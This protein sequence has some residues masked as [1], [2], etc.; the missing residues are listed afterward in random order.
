MSIPIRVIYNFV[1][2]FNVKYLENS[3][4]IYYSVYIILIIADDKK[5]Y[6]IC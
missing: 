5:P 1:I 2:F 6:M 4:L 3:I